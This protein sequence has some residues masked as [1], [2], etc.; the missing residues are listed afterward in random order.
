MLS[1]YNSIKKKPV[2]ISAG[3]INSIFSLI[4]SNQKAIVTQ[5]ITAVNVDSIIETPIINSIFFPF[6]MVRLQ[7]LEL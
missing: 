3:N 4:V 2:I 6:L 7:R 1:K 5:A